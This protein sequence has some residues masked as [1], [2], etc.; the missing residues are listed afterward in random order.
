MIEGQTVF[1]QF[2]KM[3]VAT[4]PTE[5]DKGCSPGREDLIFPRFVGKKN[6]LLPDIPPLIWPSQHQDDAET[7]K[8]RESFS[9]F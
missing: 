6:L 3:A 8:W 2:S 4:S 9:I 7:L 5:L 1:L